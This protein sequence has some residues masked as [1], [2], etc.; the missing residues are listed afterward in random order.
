MRGEIADRFSRDPLEL[1]PP[2]RNK[3]Q[4]PSQTGTCRFDFYTRDAMLARRY[5]YGCVP[6][7]LAVC[8]FDESEF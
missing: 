4:T 1:Y 8:V 6:V 7:C 3:E 2:I 5:S